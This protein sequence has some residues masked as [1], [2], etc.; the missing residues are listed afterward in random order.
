MGILPLLT[1]QVAAKWETNFQRTPT[2]AGVKIL[3]LKKLFFMSVMEKEPGY[4][5][6]YKTLGWQ[7]PELHR[8]ISRYVSPSGQQAPAGF[9]IL[10][11]S[12]GRK[13]H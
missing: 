12:H 11:R 6:T 7:S 4:E 8:S 13:R 2:E 1:L 9:S 10:L 3:S 5:A